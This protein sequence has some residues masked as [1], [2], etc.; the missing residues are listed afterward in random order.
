MYTE[1]EPYQTSSTHVYFAFPV[2]HELLWTERQMKFY[3]IQALYVPSFRNKPSEKY[4]VKVTGTE[5]SFRSST[6]NFSDLHSMQTDSI[7]QVKQKFNWG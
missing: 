7:K 6:I 1:L 2:E 4:L 5:E 3:K